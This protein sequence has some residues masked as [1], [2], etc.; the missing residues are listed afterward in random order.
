MGKVI[1]Y[2]NTDGHCIQTAARS[3]LKRLTDN[4][5]L[6]DDATTE[7]MEQVGLLTSF[8]QTADFNKLRATDTRLAGIDSSEFTLS[9]GDDGQY[10]LE[11]VVR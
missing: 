9:R 8:L 5:L 6:T 7:L 11:P 3:E 10:L 1:V 4:I 2:L